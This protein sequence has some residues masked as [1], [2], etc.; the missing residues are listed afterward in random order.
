M[1][2]VTE[3][4]NLSAGYEYDGNHRFLLYPNPHFE[5]WKK[6]KNFQL[7]S[8]YLTINVSIGFC[9]V[10]LLFPFLWVYVALH[11]LRLSSHVS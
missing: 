2:N 10:G 9:A 1:D 7:T 6:P 4:R 3:L 5:K 8:E 11:K